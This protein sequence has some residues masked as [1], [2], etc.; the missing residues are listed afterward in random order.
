MVLPQ[1]KKSNVVIEDPKKREEGTKSLVQTYKDD[2]PGQKKI[3]KFLEW[4]HEVESKTQLEHAGYPPVNQSWSPSSP[5][6]SGDTNKKVWKPLPLKA[7]KTM[8]GKMGD[9]VIRV[10]PTFVYKKQVDYAR[11]K[12]RMPTFVR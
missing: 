1:L 4:K 5:F 9:T 8:K 11:P 10:V 7:R 12:N 6:A 2:T 3:K